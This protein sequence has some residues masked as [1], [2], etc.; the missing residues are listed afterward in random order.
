MKLSKVFCRSL[1]ALCLALC[2]VFSQVS[3]YKGTFE[4]SSVVSQP[5]VNVSSGDMGLSVYF[6]G[7][8]P[9]EEGLTMS[10]I[11]PDETFSWT[12][13]ANKAIV[14][15]ISYYGS[16]SLAMPSGTLLPTGTWQLKLYYK[17]GRTLSA[18]FEVEYRDLE[19]ALERGSS[20]SESFFD[21]SSNL[22]VII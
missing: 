12:F 21:E 18:T 2:L 7:S 19:G 9:S 6:T 16:S 20:A 13:V 22:T 10:V 17:D 4:V 3:C 11:S 1:G 5:Y 14:D 8:V 15:E